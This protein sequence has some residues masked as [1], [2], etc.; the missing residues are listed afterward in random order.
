MSPPHIHNT[1]RTERKRSG[2]SQKEAAQLLGLNTSTQLSRYE[3]NHRE[4]SLK[5]ALTLQAI[6]RV[7]IH[8]LF[9]GLYLEIQSHVERRATQLHATLP[10][11]PDRLT[12]HKSAFLTTLTRSTAEQSHRSSN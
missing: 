4:P 9:A 7:P 11:S 10:K 3:H 12:T 1:L 2:L 8:E 6:Y 5:A